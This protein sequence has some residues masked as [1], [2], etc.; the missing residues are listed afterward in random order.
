MLTYYS[1]T[2]LQDAWSDFDNEE[3]DRAIALSLAE[4]EQRAIS[5]EEHQ[6]SHKEEEEEE[7]Q[8]GKKVVGESHGLS[9]NWSLLPVMVCGN[10][11]ISSL[12]PLNTAIYLT[13]M[14]F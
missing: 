12:I 10:N 4:E 8:K 13:C 9:R 14:F 11:R 3:I 6:N 7:D 5:E 1:V 2:L